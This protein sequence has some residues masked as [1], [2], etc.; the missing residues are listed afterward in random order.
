MARR[1]VSY[2]C[3]EINKKFTPC[4]FYASYIYD[5]FQKDEIYDILVLESIRL[6]S[7]YSYNG[8]LCIAS[9]VYTSIV[10]VYSYFM[11]DMPNNNTIKVNTII[12]QW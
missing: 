10:A 7:S 6:Y 9:Y 1:L 5:N 2:F 3:K 4:V 12:I 8:V 11:I